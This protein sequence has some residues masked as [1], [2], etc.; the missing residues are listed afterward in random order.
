MPTVS[1]L[2]P[3]FKPA[4]LAKTLASACAQ[5]FTDIEILVGDDT[6]DGI[7]REIA[8]AANDPRIRYFHHGFQDGLRNQE[9]L[10]AH[11]SGRYVKWLYDDDLLMPTSVATLVAALDSH[12]EST[13]A[14]HQRVVI[15]SDDK[16]IDVPA[17]LIQPGETALLD[18]A[19]LIE[20]VVVTANNFLGEPSNVMLVRER[21]NVGAMMKYREHGLIYLTDV[22]MY[23]NMAEQGPVVLAGGYHSCFR[24][25]ATQNSG[26][27]NPWLAAG[28]YEWEIMVRGEAAAG[29]IG[30]EALGK[31]RERLGEVYSFA[32]EQG[33]LSGLEPLKQSLDELGRVPPRELPASRRFL[34]GLAHSR[35]VAAAKSRKRV[36]LVC[37]TRG[38]QQQFM[39]ETA[40]GRSLRLYSSAMREDDVQIRLTINNTQGLPA[41]YNAAIEAAATDPAIL[42][43]IHDDVWLADFFWQERIHTALDRFDVVGIAGNTRRVPG[44]PAWHSTTL[45]FEPDAE[46]LSGS[47]GRGRGMPCDEVDLFG[48]PEQ[49][50]KLLDG[51]M[52]I[53]DSETLL[54][55]GVRFDE[56]FAFDFYD[57][58]FCRQAELA[59][60]RMGTWALSVIHEGGRRYGTEAWLEG[61]IRYLQKFG[62]KAGHDMPVAQVDA[63]EA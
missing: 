26:V 10:W 24:R 51:L 2:I 63:N 53:A 13:L 21:V 17:A 20:N 46:H 25:H 54:A 55:R 6:P 39:A 35:A 8:D 61:Y 32:I 58:D 44:Q 36:R 47:V 34:D 29:T 60:L 56:R 14:F 22:A 42:V 15:D 62:E 45:S 3:A 52:L 5:S 18:R 41:I 49:E 48:P 4:Y 37:A 59:G 50:C 12:P 40:L 28:F 16:V 30:A 19:F 57:L 27:A 31:A 43:F 23:L 7:L 1:I 38:D 33:G 9:Q 11:A